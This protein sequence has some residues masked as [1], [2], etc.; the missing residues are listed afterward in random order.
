[1]LEEDLLL[2]LK[3]ETE[4][5]LSGFFDDKIKQV[6]KQKKPKEFLEITKNLKK[7]VLS[8]GKRI[9]PILFHCGYFIANGRKKADILKASISIEL[10]HSYL[11][12]HDD[13]IDRD[14]FRHNDL[15]MH[16][17]Y[18]KRYEGFSD[19][20]S[21]EGNNMKHFGISMAILAG[22]FVS[23][24][25]YEILTNSNFPSDLKIKAIK[26]LNQIISN[27]ITGEAMDVALA[28]YPGADMD[29]V[30][31]MQRYKTA[32]YTIEG[33]LHLGA[34]LAG[35]D[36]KFLESISEFAIPLGIAFQIQDDIVGVF[37]NKKRTGKLAGA[38]IKE[39]KKTLLSIKAF[40]KAN[41]EQL[42]ILSESF[43]NKNIDRNEIDAVRRIIEETGSLEYSL[44]RIEDLI[45]FSKT[46]LEKM[47]ISEKY[48][49]FLLRL[50]T[51]S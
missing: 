36:K 29:E 3:N 15:S 27:T 48:K 39:G 5:E 37:G 2:K 44:K 45:R 13:I 20:S 1:M 22:D 41:G 28:E 7:F 31:K 34:I 50:T 49:K 47:E 25:G 21:Q 35:A 40:K 12:I 42:K 17:R 8:G 30:I 16:C 11:L 4:K 43:G 51:L 14:N 38:D 23:S 24:L 46:R 32:K 10:I 9:R 19:Y 6:E 18:E 26:K 33:P